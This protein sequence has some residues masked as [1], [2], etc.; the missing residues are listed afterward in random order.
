MAKGKLYYLKVDHN[1]HYAPS[2]L[3]VHAKDF[4]GTNELPNLADLK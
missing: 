3:S 2:M 4:G 1:L